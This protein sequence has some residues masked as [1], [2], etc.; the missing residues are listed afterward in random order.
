VETALGEWRAIGGHRLW[1]SPEYPGSYAPDNLPLSPVCEGD[2]AVRLIQET[3]RAGIQKTMHVALDGSG[4]HVAVRHTITNRTCWPI[5]VAPWALSIVRTD[6]VAVIPQPPFQSHDE[7]W[8]PVR[9]LGQWAFT[10]L[11]DDRWSIGPQLVRLSVNSARI[12]PQKIGVGN[13][14][15]WC[16]L[17]CPSVVFVKRFGWDRSLAYPDFGSNNE[18]YTAANFLELETLGPLSTLSPEHSAQHVEHW[19]LFPPIDLRL[20]EARLAQAL[21]ELVQQARN[22]SGELPHS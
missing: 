1:V 19:H 4:S 8:Q 21:K 13:A 10:D 9:P 15:G 16:A 18:V 22:T 11:S 5:T 6:G 2:T 14:E 17:V 12:E 3:D 20:P 7:N